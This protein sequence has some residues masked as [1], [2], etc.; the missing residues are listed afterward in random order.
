MLSINNQDG[1]QKQLSGVERK[2]S[3]KILRLLII[4]EAW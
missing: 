3:E 1:T 4:G 2:Q